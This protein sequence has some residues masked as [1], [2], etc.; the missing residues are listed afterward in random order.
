M[1]TQQMQAIK[2]R[3]ELISQRVYGPSNS[4]RNL[5][6]SIYKNPL[7]Y[8]HNAPKQKRNDPPLEYPFF[9]VMYD[10]GILKRNNKQETVYT[11]LFR[12]E[13]QALGKAYQAERSISVIDAINQ[14]FNGDNR[15]I[16]PNTNLY[17]TIGNE[18]K[19]QLNDFDFENITYHALIMIHVE[20]LLNRP[21][22]KGD[23]KGFLNS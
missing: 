1:I 9:V 11:I 10:S 20:N 21:D 2:N 15:L 8:L 18:I 14:D 19:S 3:L 5:A 6:D 12:S 22:L 17:C 4:D 13:N 23:D 16:L 7:V